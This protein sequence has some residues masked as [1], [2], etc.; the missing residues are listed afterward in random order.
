MMKSKWGLIITLTVV[1]LF[2]LA[3]CGKAE[4]NTE[5][6]VETTLATQTT[7]TVATETMATEAVASKLQKIKDKGTLVL[8]TSADYPPFEFHLEV[9]GKDTIVGFDI[10]IAQKIADSIG[11]KLEILDMKFDG[12]LPALTAG[13]IDLIVSGMTPTDER[14]Q[15]VDFSIVYYEARQ[16]MLVLS[17]DAAD[18]NTI[19]AFDGKTL[20]VQKATIQ[21][22][23]A[24]T[25]FTNSK[26]KAIDKIPN[27]ILELKTGKVDGLIIAEP[28]GKQYANA[29][30]DLALNGIDLGSEGGSAVAVQ[31]D[32]GDF[33]DAINAA[34]QDMLDSGEMDQVISDAMLL[35]EGE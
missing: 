34:I 30:D 9:D 12:L 35:S 19:E 32:S 17:K 2:T 27:L 28:V 4:A 5:T 26:A 25:V 24:K 10:D 8:G 20:G 29:N 1:M 7:E 33:L 15:S 22:E 16:T 14:K 23:L 18:L 13:K 6:T 11:V 3:G 21:E 31:K